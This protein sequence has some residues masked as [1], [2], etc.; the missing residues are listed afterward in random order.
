MTFNYNLD[1]LSNEKA[2]CRCGAKNCSGFIGARP[3]N[4]SNDT[5][6]SRS[7]TSIKS[8]TSNESSAS[9]EIKNT[10]K[11]K[12][13]DAKKERLSI[14]L[15]KS[16]GSVPKKRAM[17]LSSN[18]IK[19]LEDKLPSSNEVEE[20]KNNKIDLVIKKESS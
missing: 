6:V 1:S 8:E 17:S 4:N 15:P 16:N 13:N 9:E 19:K 12:L 14:C 11:R 7:N 10:K 2:V 18:E 20:A 5:K 3:K